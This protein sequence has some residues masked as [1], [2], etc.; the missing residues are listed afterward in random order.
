LKKNGIQ[1]YRLL[2]IWV[3]GDLAHHGT[4]NPIGGH[5]HAQEWQVAMEQFLKASYYHKQV[6]KDPHVLV[7]LILD[8]ETYA[9]SMD[10]LRH[11]QK[12][13][14]SHL[15]V[16][17][18]ESFA[19]DH[20]I[21]EPMRQC[22]QGI[23]SI[24]SDFLRSWCLEDIDYTMNVYLDIDTFSE[25]YRHRWS[26]KSSFLLGAAC[27]EKGLWSVLRLSPQMMSWNGDMLISYG[28]KI[29]WPLLKA[30]L[31]QN[32]N[33]YERPFRDIY[34]RSQRLN[35]PTFHDY[36]VD[37]TQRKQWWH[38]HPEL[39]FDQN[40]IILEVI[41]PGFW[42]RQLLTGSAYPYKRTQ[43]VDNYFSWCDQQEL[44]PMRPI[45][46]QDIINIFG[47][48]QADNYLSLN[49]MLY[50]YFYF[51]KFK[52]SWIKALEDE[53]LKIADRLQIPEAFNDQFM[54]MNMV[55]DFIINHRLE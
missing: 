40:S 27:V 32:Y 4:I 15:K 53:I 36:E 45:S 41:G 2:S 6:K 13:Y 28:H 42:V 55:K 11:W 23:P 34:Q 20:L 1:E 47:V 54:N 33:L 51:K 39:N 25:A 17:L 16:T 12:T 26:Q 14:P 43:E 19:D 5:K 46:L 24:C 18:L 3:K 50:D 44:I 9:T 37:L 52:L 10:L 35:H 30:K 38:A 29:D 22:Q 8:K 21:D 7:E 48:D 49:L 31:L